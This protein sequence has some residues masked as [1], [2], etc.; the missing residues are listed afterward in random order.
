MCNAYNATS[1]LITSLR[2]L[3]RKHTPSATRGT[4]RDEDVKASQ[5]LPKRQTHLKLVPKYLMHI[6]TPSHLETSGST[7]RRATAIATIPHMACLAFS[8][9]LLTTRKQQQKQQALQHTRAP[10]V[11]P[12]ATEGS[13]RPQAWARPLCPCLS[14]RQQGRRA[15]PIPA[16]PARQALPEP[17]HVEPPRPAAR[18]APAAASPATVWPCTPRSPQV[19]AR[20]P[21]R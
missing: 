3:D 18:E 13:E 11:P 8:V 9:P 15:P 17:G 10:Q 19:R 2:T 6:Y 4:G 1:F 16:L 7:C 5:Q 12:P 14:P 21:R 20:T